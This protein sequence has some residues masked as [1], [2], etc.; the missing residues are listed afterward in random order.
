MFKLG[1]ETLDLPKVQYLPAEAEDY[2]AEVTGKN[3]SIAAYTLGLME[4]TDPEV[5]AKVRA[6]R[7]ARDQVEDLLVAWREA[8]SVTEGESSDSAKS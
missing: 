6:A 4:A 1:D 2:I 5:G 7:L 8:S 3:L